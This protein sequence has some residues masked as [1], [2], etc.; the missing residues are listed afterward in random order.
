MPIMEVL[1]SQVG[2]DVAYDEMRQIL[3]RLARV[4][5]HI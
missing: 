4:K 1:L 3:N 2:I 5:G